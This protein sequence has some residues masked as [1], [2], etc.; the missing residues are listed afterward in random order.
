MVDIGSSILADEPG[1]A[2]LN[3]N[4]HHPSTHGLIR[5]RLTVQNQHIVSANT[6]IG[7]M[8]RGVEKLLESRDFRQGLALANRHDWLGAFSGELG[9]ALALESMLGLDV[10]P[11]A[12]WLRTLVAE[13]TRVISHLYFLEYFPHGLSPADID[14][15]VTSVNSS[16]LLRDQAQQLLETLTGGR[17]HPM[18]VQ[19]GGLRHDTPAGWT[20]QVSH[21][22]TAARKEAPIIAPYLLNPTFAELMRGVGVITHDMAVAHGASG[23]VGRASGIDVDLR[24]DAPYAA[25]E[26]LRPILRVPTGE[27][28][29]VVTRLSIIRNQ[30]DVA[31]DL[32][33]RCVDQL[34][35]L[36]GP[37]NVPLPKT[38]RAPEGVHYGWSETP[39][40]IG[41][42]LIVSQGER[43]PWRV[44]LRTPSFAH[45]DLLAHCLVGE[46]I[47]NL[48]PIVGSLFIITGD[49]DR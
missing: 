25:Y 3:L 17:V 18:Y 14:T 22:T 31:L 30:L 29:D 38:L 1:T 12:S 24:R 8:H 34:D 41:G 35:G 6:D 13:L 9:Y 32:I 7:Y 44:K 23:A 20:E 11:R 42:Y 5:L 43:T 49:A 46:H 40:G 37:I 48:G 4:P 15:P 28:G 2:H 39:L 21:F 16:I 19:V 10:P 36:D 26:D 47:K 33:D 45:V 27:A